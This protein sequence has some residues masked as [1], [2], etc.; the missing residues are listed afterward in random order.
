MSESLPGTA[1]LEDS[2]ATSVEAP[3]PESV[4]EV[5]T[6][7]APGQQPQMVEASRFNGLMGRFNRTQNELNEALQRIAELESNAGTPPAQ[8][9]SNV[10]NVEGLQ[11][12]IASLQAMLMEQTLDKARAEAL[13][14]FPGAKAFADLIV[15]NTPE[16]VREMAKV[17]HERVSA[18]TPTTTEESATEGATSEAATQEPPVEPTPTAPQVAGG[19]TVTE[20]PVNPQE[21]VV[22]AIQRGSFSDYL[23]AKWEATKASEGLVL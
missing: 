9:E 2:A 3:A 7:S 8:E 1:P 22:E 14:E 17:L 12:Q 5:V 15:A 11:S 13:Q 10:S 21:R 6:E 4:E 20:A 18:N 23:R 19:T 16:E